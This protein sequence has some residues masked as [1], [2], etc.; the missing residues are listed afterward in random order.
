MYSLRKALLAGVAAGAIGCVSGGRASAQTPSNEELYKMILGLKTEQQKLRQENARSQAEARQARAELEKAREQL[1][2]AGLESDSAR[3]GELS[4]ARVKGDPRLAAASTQVNPSPYGGLPRAGL[5]A[6]SA[7]NVRLD[8][9]GGVSNGSGAGYVSGA[10]NAPIDDAFGLQANGFSGSRGSDM[11]LG[12]S[13]SAFWRDP[14]KGLVGLYGSASRSNGPTLTNPFGYTEGKVGAI[15]QFYANRFSIEAAAGFQRFDLANKFFD[16]VDFV[17]YPTDNWRVSV[18]HRRDYGRDALALGTE[19]KLATRGDLGLSLFAEGRVG[20]K[21]ELSALAGLKVYFGADNKSLLRRQRE[22]D[23][24]SYLVDDFLMRPRSRYISLVGPTGATGATGPQGP[25]GLTGPTGPT[26]SPGVTGPTGP[27]GPTGLTGPTGPTGL[28]GV[29]GPTGPAGSPGLIGPTGPTGLPGVTGPT[30]PI[31][32]TGLTG[33]TGPTGL[34]GVTGPTGPAGS[35]GLIGPTG[36]T[37]LPGVT[38]PTGPIGPTGLT[39]PT[40]PTGL[41]GVTGPTGPTGPSGPV[42]PPGFLE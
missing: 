8:G 24:P 1:R 25:T 34:P 38:G 30:G 42:G 11:F 20:Q 7:V 4:A 19:Y 36:P 21:S 39:G 41:P 10:V 27:I 17:Y 6:I 28:P 15:A 13:S 16:A 5:P 12:G 2:K 3:R 33:P 23:A 18:G 31:G 26:G 35:P 9:A 37:G 40:G 29:T 22:D 32:P 14:S